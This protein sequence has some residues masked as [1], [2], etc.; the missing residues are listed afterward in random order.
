MGAVVQT[1]QQNRSTLSVEELLFLLLLWVCSDQ[2]ELTSDVLVCVTK[3]VL[4]S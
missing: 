3:W 4:S 2:R 1:E